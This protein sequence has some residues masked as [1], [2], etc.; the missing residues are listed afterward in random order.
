M[1]RSSG[2]SPPMARGFASPTPG[3]ETDTHEP[4][5]EKS[6][7]ASPGVVAATPTTSFLTGGILRPVAVLVPRRRDE[8]DSLIPDLLR[9]HFL[10][11]LGLDLH[12]EAQVDDP[13]A[14]LDG[15]LDAARDVDRGPHAVA[16]KDADRQ[17][18]CIRRNR[19]DEAG[20]NVP[21]PT[22]SSTRSSSSLFTPSGRSE[23]SL[24]PSTRSTAP[25]AIRPES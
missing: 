22:A 3:A 4:Q 20:H 15:D 11:D 16:V 19:E 21:C 14:A 8:D 5:L 7:F 23:G 2:P 17:H 1:C 24:S 6:A 12:A 25:A 10:E 13:G 9:D 18:P